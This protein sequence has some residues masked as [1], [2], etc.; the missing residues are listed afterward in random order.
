ME[1]AELGEEDSFDPT[2]PETGD[3]VA[4]SMEESNTT[5]HAD[6]NP[7]TGSVEVPPSVPPPKPYRGATVESNHFAS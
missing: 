3:A 6:D 7:Q 4:S 5:R 1:L 2:G